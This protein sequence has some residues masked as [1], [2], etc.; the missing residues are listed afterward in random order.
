M[1]AN[2]CL[3]ELYLPAPCKLHFLDQE[4]ET[5]CSETETPSFLRPGEKCGKTVCGKLQR[6]F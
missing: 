1:G 6:L 4:V 2:I 5:E 3:K